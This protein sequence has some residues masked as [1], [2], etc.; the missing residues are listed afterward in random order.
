MDSE[1]LC[2]PYWQIF[3]HSERKHSS[4]KNRVAKKS[5]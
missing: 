1:E 3:M 5:T 4:I 2:D